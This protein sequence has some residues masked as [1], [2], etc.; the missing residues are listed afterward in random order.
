MSYSA[1]QC[2]IPKDIKFVLDIKIVSLMLD[3]GQKLKKWL[4]FV[5][6]VSSLNILLVGYDCC[7]CYFTSLLVDIIIIDSKK[8]K[9]LVDI[10][11]CKLYS[12]SKCLPDYCTFTC[13]ANSR[14]KRFE[15]RRELY[16]SIY[17]VRLQPDVHS[18][19]RSAYHSRSIHRCC[20]LLRARLLRG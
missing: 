18:N 13:V 2:H 16:V 14:V 19:H 3:R 8:R 7:K 10:D 4:N 17:F 20:P 12:R 11:S 1:W 9:K 6:V 5:H 15:T